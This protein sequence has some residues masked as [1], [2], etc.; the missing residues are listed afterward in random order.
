MRIYDTGMST[1]RMQLLVEKVNISCW[2]KDWALM[3]GFIQNQTLLQ[4]V[5]AVAVAQDMCRRRLSIS[6]VPNPT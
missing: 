6:P 4:V 5:K 1:P 3:P 2:Q